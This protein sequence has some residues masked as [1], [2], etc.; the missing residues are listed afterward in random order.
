MNDGTDYRA[1]LAADTPLID[2]RAPIEFTQGAMPTAINLPLM[3]NEER[4]A[5]GTCY[6]R[7]GPEAALALGH[8]LVAGDE[9]QRRLEAWRKACIQHPR[10]YLCCARGGQRSHIVQQW[11]HESGVDYPLIQGGYKAL[12]QAAMHITDTLVQ[13]PMILI[14]GCTG[15]GKTQLVRQ[16]PNGVDLE[17]LAHHRGSS[18][19]R[20]LKPQLSQASFE[21][22]L[23]VEM[24]KTDA[25]QELQMWVLEDEGR[26]IGANHLPECLRERMAQA[27]IAV[28]DDPFELRLERLREEYFIRMH[29]DFTHTCGEEDGW[30]A[31]SDYLHH[32][33]SAIQRR[34]GLQ[35]FKELT[36]KLDAA[37]T[38][39]QASGSTDGHLAWLVPLLNEYYDPMYRYQLE[40]KAAKIVFRGIWQDVAQW[41]QN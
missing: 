39:Q 41:L 16:Q 10:G 31:Y 30:Q 6:K 25:R 38:M 36:V 35:R 9:R 19:G 21:N 24:L 23:A 29:R 7:Q 2:V 3:N 26:M 34:L 18:F 28:V 27:S 40:K 33:L 5:V 17:G 4:A 20:T 32:G 22:Q 37:L 13:K 1:I 11:L 12:R 14:G 15:S 8:K